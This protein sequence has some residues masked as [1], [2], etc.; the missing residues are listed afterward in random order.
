MAI[1]EAGEN[2]LEQLLLLSL[3]KEKVRAIDL[4]VALGFARPTVSVMLRDL[5]EQGFIDRLDD[6]TL[7]LTEKGRTVAERI[8]ER[9]CV[10]TD[11]LAAL[12]VPREIAA[13]DACK[14]EHDISDEA[15][16]AVK[17]HLR[18]RSPSQ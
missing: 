5:R 15:F 18:E 11:M 14:I 6:D 12:G 13:A 2:Y 17:R 9:H 7:L 10:L 1:H 8:Y 16:E 3:K 4:A